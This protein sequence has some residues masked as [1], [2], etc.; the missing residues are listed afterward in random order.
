M[1]VPPGAVVG[2]MKGRVDCDAS[3]RSCPNGGLCSREGA[4]EMLGDD[5]G[6]G[7]G[8]GENWL[9]GSGC[10][11]PAALPPPTPTRRLAK[12]HTRH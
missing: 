8:D 10:F 11:P 9:D 5:D 7:D 12:T 4:G 2:A 1:A 3:S 6:D